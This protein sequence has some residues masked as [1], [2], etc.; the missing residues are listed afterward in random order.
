MIFRRILLSITLY[1]C[2]LSL[3]CCCIKEASICDFIRRRWK[4]GSRIDERSVGGSW[5]RGLIASDCWRL[6]LDCTPAKSST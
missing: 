4:S 3:L 2:G 1:N 5:R 6:P